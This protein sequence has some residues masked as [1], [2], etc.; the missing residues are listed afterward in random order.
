MTEIAFDDRRQNISLKRNLRFL[1]EGQ[2][3]PLNRIS[4]FII[5][6]NKIIKRTSFWTLSSDV[7]W[8]VFVPWRWLVLF[9]PTAREGNVFTGVCQSFCSLLASWLL[10]HCSSLSWRGR[11][12]SYWNAFLLIWFRFACFLCHK[13]HFYVLVSVVHCLYTLFS[14]PIHMFSLFFQTTFLTKFNVLFNHI[15]IQVYWIIGC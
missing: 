9:L 11:Y 14:K 13:M 8:F 2:R 10:R 12:A 6:T 1:E 15:R 7:L 5:Y 4:D 3:L